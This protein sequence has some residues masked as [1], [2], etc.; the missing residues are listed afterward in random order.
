MQIKKCF[1]KQLTTLSAVT[2]LSK[3]EKIKNIEHSKFKLPYLILY[4]E[5]FTCSKSATKTQV[6]GVK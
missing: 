1:L 5:S 2:Q 3:I 6:K 4:K